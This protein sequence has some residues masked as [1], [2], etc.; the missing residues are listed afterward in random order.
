MELD[1]DG[2]KNLKVNVIAGKPRIADIN[3]N[4][5]EED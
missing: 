3:L 1:D 5:L 2:K 4:L